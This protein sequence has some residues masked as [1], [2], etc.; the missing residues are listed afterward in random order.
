MSS[1]KYG[2]EVQPSS[3]SIPLLKKET[4]HKTNPSHRKKA[5]IYVS[6]MLEYF[7]HFSIASFN[8]TNRILA[9]LN[10]NPIVRIR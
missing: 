8:V 10:E 5:K 7:H 4:L 3:N 9:Q 6:S 2:H 1:N